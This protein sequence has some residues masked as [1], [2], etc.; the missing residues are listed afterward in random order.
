[1]KQCLSNILMC[2]ECPESHLHTKTSERQRIILSQRWTPFLFIQN[3]L[4]SLESISI[5]EYV[6]NNSKD[7]EAV[8]TRSGHGK[9]LG[10]PGRAWRWGRVK[11]YNSISIK[12]T[13]WG[14]VTEC[15]SA[16]DCRDAIWRL[17]ERR[18]QKQ[19]LVKEFCWRRLK[20]LSKSVTFAPRTQKR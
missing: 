1:M 20:C 2:E 14:A 5:Y 6:C 12:N 16:S 18:G 10:V 11:W 15:S 9:G 3:K 8:N 17:K 4:V 7:K 19:S 13:L